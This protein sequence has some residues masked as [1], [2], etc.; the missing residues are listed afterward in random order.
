MQT[1]SQ[2]MSTAK[3][4]FPFAAVQGQGLFKLSLLLAAVNPLVGGVLISGPR[5][6]AK[7]TLARALA[8][9]LPLDTGQTKPFVTL[10]LG[11]SEEMLVGTLDLQQVLDNDQLKFQPGLLAKAD[12]GILYLDEVNLLPDNLVDHL[13]D[14]AAS[15][16]NIVERD[17]ISHQHSA[18]FILL[19]TMN[20]DEGELRPQLQ[21]R[22][23]LHVALDN[24]YSID[25]RI[26]IV[27]QREQFDRDPLGFCQQYQPQQQ[28][29]QQQIVAAQRLLTEVVCEQEL[30][31]LIAQKCLDARVDGLRADIVW[32]QAALAHASL[33]AR[34]Q[35]QIDDIEAVEQ[36]VL[37]HRRHDQQPPNS[38]PPH[39]KPSNTEPPNTGTPN[40]GASGSSSPFQRPS[41]K[42]S[43]ASQATVDSKAQGDW[44]SMP[45]EQQQ[46][47]EANDITLAFAA[48]NLPHT[49]AAA[50]NALNSVGSKQAQQ[51]APRGYMSQQ[52]GDK[53]SWFK[54]LL[55]SYGK[56][57]FKT[58]HYA[59]RKRGERVV[60]LVLLDT[61]ASVLDNRAFAKA[62]GLILQLAQQAYLAREQFMLLGFGNQQVSK[63][64]DLRRAPKSMLAE[65]N[66]IS[67][68]GGTPLNQ[69]LAE[70]RQFQL[71]Q[72]R[73]DASVRFKNTI[74]TDG[75][76]QQL[77]LQHEL[78]GDSIVVDSEQS[79]VRRGKSKQLA[80][81]LQAQYMQLNANLSA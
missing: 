43:A 1:S 75:R 35:V 44:G 60:N 23:G 28:Q 45:A 31:Q 27:S 55:A 9:I 19:G 11:A 80:E 18:N 73:K 49:Q 52:A 50:I 56:R 70:M 25:D 26:F 81:I 77:S 57:P 72:Q 4:A 3:P 67:A 15:G 7:S 71:Q 17:G 6:S 22:F 10:P 48:Q 63:L 39:S 30:R 41:E 69:A 16:V 12:Q 33:A 5:G 62:K 42:P 24:Q 79:Q 29:L 78:D 66:R 46:L 34:R 14:V 59:K 53:V 40:T 76:V 2:I 54:T 36:L 8:D 13:L 68:A 65:L 74:I 20:P 38:A 21:D 47:L 64:I 58:L 37:S 61:S 51:F 32:L